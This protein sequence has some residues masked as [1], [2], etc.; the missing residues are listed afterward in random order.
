MEKR[1]KKS[2]IFLALERG[3]SLNI[4]IKTEASEIGKAKGFASYLFVRNALI[5]EIAKSPRASIKSVVSTGKPSKEC[6]K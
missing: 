6:R 2:L 1:S 3:N 5:E 4:P